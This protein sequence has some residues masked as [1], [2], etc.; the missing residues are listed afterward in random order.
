M[1]LKAQCRFRARL[2]VALEFLIFA[3]A[4]AP[5]IFTVKPY[6]SRQLWFDEALTLLNFACLDSPV[7]IYL[8]YVIPNNH[9][10]YT[11]VLHYFLKLLPPGFP[12]DLW[13]RLPSLVFAVALL[14][15]TWRRFRRVCGALPLWITLALLAISPPFLVFATAVRGYML[16]A[17]FSVWAAGCALELAAS[18][19][20][21]PFVKYFIASLGAVLTVPSDLAALTGAVLFALPWC[22][23][24]FWKERKFYV[25]ALTPL[26]ALLLAYLPIS[27]NF[28]AV[29]QL[30]EGWRDRWNS[31][32]A[33]GLA[34]A[35]AFGALLLLIPVEWMRGVKRRRRELWRAAI[36]F[37]PLPAAFVFAVA[38]FPRVYFP[39]FP[40]LALTVARALRRFGGAAWH[41]RASS[42]SVHLKVV[43]G[44]GILVF[45]VSMWHP[46][47]GKL[48]PHVGGDLGDDFFYGYHL[49]PEHQPAK[50]AAALE[51]LK[52]ET[53][54]FSFL[55]DPWAN[56][57]YHLTRGGK[58]EYL[59]DGPRG[60]VE[61]L[62][63]GAAAVLRRDESP[64]V[65]ER[66]F[67]RKLRQVSETPACKIF[68]VE[69]L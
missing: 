69:A 5:L 35:S 47:L 61:E 2:P 21:K 51:K 6:L 20:I 13:L 4:L 24:K 67:A 40:I 1:N 43:V 15:Y 52:V 12:P 50:V 37:L 28:I 34:L 39:L 27:R 17:L 3:V 55:S 33:V 54:Y 11:V 66:R 62:P 10:L 57:F 63:V 8:A 64:E 59:F 26:A 41:R 22:G 44:V 16:G 9:I 29:A 19:R 38:P 56:M 7:D 65:L 42:G 53:V 48:S 36:W 23:A 45:S 49:R 46:V 32:A 60:R 25:L 31:L 14:V 68:I 18:F 30:G 58:A